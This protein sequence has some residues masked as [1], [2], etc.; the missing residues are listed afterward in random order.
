MDSFTAFSASNGAAES[1]LTV[2][3]P[4]PT[5]YEYAE[6]IVRGHVAESPVYQ[7]RSPGASRSEGGG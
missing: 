5:D 2:A 7:D 4:A 3:P 6:L 1:R